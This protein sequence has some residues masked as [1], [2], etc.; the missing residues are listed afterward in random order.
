MKQQSMK[1]T[2]GTGLLVLLILGQAEG[3]TLSSQVNEGGGQEAVNNDD[4]P[5]PIA[6]MRDY[7]AL[8]KHQDPT[9]MCIE[10]GVIAQHYRVAKDEESEA[11]WQMLSRRDCQA[12]E[13]QAKA[14]LT[15]KEAGKTGETD[16]GER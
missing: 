6:L 1:M 16:K 7:Q 11:Q 5:A 4:T 13:A 8:V 10:S 3:L 15:A 9:G 12:A 14:L 2:L